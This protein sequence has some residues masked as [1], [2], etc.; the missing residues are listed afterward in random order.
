MTK[1]QQHLY[2]YI[3]EFNVMG[4]VNTAVFMFL[5]HK[6]NANR[7]LEYCLGRVGLYC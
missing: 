5:I 3:C 6:Q 4:H 1:K 2:T 7:Y